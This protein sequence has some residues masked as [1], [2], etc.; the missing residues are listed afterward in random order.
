MNLMFTVDDV[1]VAVSTADLNENTNLYTWVRDHSRLNGK[2]DP[3]VTALKRP[4]NYGD[5]ATHASI[6]AKIGKEVFDL[7]PKNSE[8]LSIAEALQIVRL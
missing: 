7:P 8:T 4:A 2:L 1:T 5:A 6:A 3:I